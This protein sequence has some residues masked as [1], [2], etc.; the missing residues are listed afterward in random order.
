MNE[1]IKKPLNPSERM[2]DYEMIEFLQKLGFDMRDEL[3]NF[4]DHPVK[5]ISINDFNRIGFDDPY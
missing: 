1:D 5:N 2:S 3:N 4:S